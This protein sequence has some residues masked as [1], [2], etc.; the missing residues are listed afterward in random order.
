MDMRTLKTPGLCF[1]NRKRIMMMN[2]EI[3]PLKGLGRL[4][5]GLSKNEVVRQL[6]EADKSELIE[7]PDGLSTEI[8]TYDSLQLE[9]SFEEEEDRRLGSL[10]MFNGELLLKGKKIIGLDEM[11]FVDAFIQLDLGSILSEKTDPE[12]NFYNYYC[13][14]SNMMIWISDGVVESIT[15]MP[16]YD[17]AGN[18]TVWPA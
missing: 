10:E 12:D 5:F 9:C 2:G 11:R 3:K 14:D 13:R 18:K 17:L 8:W 4:V 6:G 7:Y 15:L 16:E 1:F